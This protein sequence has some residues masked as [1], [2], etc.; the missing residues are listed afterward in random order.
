MLIPMQAW[1]KHLRARVNSR[2]LLAAHLDWLMLAFMQWGA[3]FLIS[4]WPATSAR[5]LA[6]LMVFWR[7]D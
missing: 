6:V 7:L 1:G 3:A 4:T 2:A 5:A